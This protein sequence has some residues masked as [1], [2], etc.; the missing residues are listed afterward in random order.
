MGAY[1]PALF[2]FYAIFMS[3][4]KIGASIFLIYF[5]VSVM[6]F[7]KMKIKLDE[8]RTAQINWFIKLYKNTN[9]KL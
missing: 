9:E 2:G 7:M 6:K 1:I 3:L 4:I 8:Q 5:F